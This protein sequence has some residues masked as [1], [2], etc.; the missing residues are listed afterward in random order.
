MLLPA[1]KFWDRANRVPVLLASAGMVA[2][3]AVVDWWTTPY[4]SLGLLYL[5][6]ISLAAGFLPRSVLVV[7]C[8][9][10]AVLSEAFSSL[11]PA[12]RPIRLILEMSAFAGCGLFV[13]ELL[14]NRRLS[15]ETQARLR[16][17]AETSPAAIVTLDEHG[18]V[19]LANRAAVE[20]M[21]TSESDLTGRPIAPFLPGLEKALQ[22]DGGAEF[23]ASMQCQGHRTGGESF[24]AE[25]WFSTY[26]DNGSPKL[27]AIYRR[28]YRRAAG[29]GSFRSGW[30][31]RYGT[32]EPEQPPGGCPAACIR[33]PVEQ[34]NR[35]TP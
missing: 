12:A 26:R 23:R 19:E 18:V 10:C 24:V 34:S 35:R 7:V 13:A 30:T 15:L 6:P 5:L 16:A 20:L 27:A 31:G 17:L 32:G 9:G 29:Q 21:V 11:D 14:R 22:S 8:I 2:A 4:W 28:C 25:V 1:E 3:I 33:G